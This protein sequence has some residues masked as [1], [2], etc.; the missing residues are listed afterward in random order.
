MAWV[1]K[2]LGRK[3]IWI[4]CGLHVNELPLRSLIEN[5]DGKTSSSTGLSG[6]L[7]KA[8]EKVGELPLNPC[9][10]K[11]V[12]SADLP[13]MSDEVV[14][15]LSE[16]QK[17]AFKLWA[18]IRSGEMTSDLA[19]MACGPIN[20]SGWLTTANRFCSLWTRKHG[21]VGENLQS[22]IMIVKWI[23]GSYYPMWFKLK[24]NHH[25]IHGPC[26]LLYQLQ[27]WRVHHDV[28]RN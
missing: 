18:A 17:H 16:D 5:L 25:W 1:E 21:F 23:V 20:H 2:S 9:Y 14:N 8:L 26:H 19:A 15:D 10:E 13:S 7:G 28:F 22:L 11:I 3:L 6:P 4:V 27:L 24:I 12:T